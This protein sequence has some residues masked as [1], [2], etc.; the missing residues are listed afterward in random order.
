MLAYIFVSGS[1]IGVYDLSSFTMSDEPTECVFHNMSLSHGMTV[2]TIVRC[3][4][5]VEL[6]ADVTSQAAVVTTEPPSVKQ[7]SVIFIEQNSRSLKGREKHFIA[8]QNVTKFRSAGQLY[9]QSNSFSVVMEWMGFEDATEVD[10]YE[11]RLLWKDTAI[12]DW[13]TTA[14]KTCV[15]IVGLNLKGD[16]YYKAEVRAF[17]SGNY[18]S[19]PVSA[20]LSVKNKEPKLTGELLT[21]YKCLN[22]HTILECL[23]DALIDVKVLFPAY[24]CRNVMW[25]ITKTRLYN[26]DPLKPHFYIVKLGFTGVYIIFLISAQNMDCGYSLEPPRRGGS[27]EYPHSMF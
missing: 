12:R 21:V 9:I 14:K 20:L 22:I 3:V 8:D 16:E 17:N 2:Y 7:A 11:Y 24:V 4:N 19:E 18:V 5:R 26:V 25:H 13:T 27:N 23:H 1:R 15:S 10:H 6:S